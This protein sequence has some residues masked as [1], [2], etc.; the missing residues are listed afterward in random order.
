M[1]SKAAFKY[2]FICI[3]VL[4]CFFIFSSYLAA[5]SIE[6]PFLWKIEG[7]KTTSYLFGTIHLPDA[8]VTTLHSSVEQAFKDSEYVYTEIPLDTS[9]ML[10]QVNYL[11]L[12]GDQTLADIVEPDLLQRADNIV[13]GINPVLTIDPFLKFKVWALATSLPLL[14]QQLNNPGVLP[15]DAQL[16]QRA[17]NEGKGTGGIETIQ[18]QLGYFD[19]LTQDE[20]IKMLRDTIEFMEEADSKE[21]SLAEEFIRYYM[22]GDVEAF[23]QLMVKY[24]KE[25]EFS[26]DFMKKILDDRNIIMADRIHNKLTKNPDRSY[27]F[28]VGAGHYWNETGVQNL[29]EKKGISLTR[30]EN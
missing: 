8:R 28:A 13:K 14:E 25:D 22:Q 15:L 11:M 10:A 2:F 6:K 5:E 18:E 29:L 20:E 7:E 23:G 3:Y 26:K 19:N 24:I 21:Q 1:I 16:Y 12:E 30:V 17:G 27:F 4:L 9:D